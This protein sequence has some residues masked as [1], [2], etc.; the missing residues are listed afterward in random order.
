[1]RQLL[2]KGLESHDA[3]A[4]FA[5]MILVG[6]TRSG[7]LASD[8]SQVRRSFCLM[9]LAFLD[10]SWCANLVYG[11]EVYGWAKQANDPASQ[12]RIRAMIRRST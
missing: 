7:S 2:A 12:F 5:S 6:F 11:S 1:M 10:A 4:L 9:A 8:S 3:S